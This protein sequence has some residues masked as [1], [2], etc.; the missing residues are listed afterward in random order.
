MRLWVQ[1]IVIVV[2]LTVL[3]AALALSPAKHSPIVVF[4]LGCVAGAVEHIIRTVRD[5][6]HHGGVTR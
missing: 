3:L 2:I 6:R 5:R 1:A 4:I